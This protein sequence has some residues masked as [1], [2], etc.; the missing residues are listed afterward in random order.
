[1]RNPEISSEQLVQ[2][3]YAIR[4]RMPALPVLGI[5]W[6]HRTNMRDPS[7]EEL[8][9]KNR[10]YRQLLLPARFF[11]LVLKSVCLIFGTLLLRW[12]FRAGSRFLKDQRVDIVAKSWHFANQMP[13]QSKDFYY[14]QIQQMFFKRGLSF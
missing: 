12:R 10:N 14:G 9:A 3:C 6:M 1:M 5:Q 2:A 11:L 7:H 8:L 13:L 4:E